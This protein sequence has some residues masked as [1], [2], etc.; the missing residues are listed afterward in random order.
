MDECVSVMCWFVGRL[1]IITRVPLVSGMLM[2]KK[3]KP[4]QQ[5]SQ[6]KLPKKLVSKL[7]K[8][9]DRDLAREFGVSELEI[10][11]E[12]RRLGIAAHGRR[13]WTKKEIAL[14]GTAS[15][16]EI[17]KRLNRIPSGVFLQR[18]LPFLRTQQHN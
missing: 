16:A 18:I 8:H 5:A 14:L 4:S 11:K 7:G 9:N 2:K 10:G 12:R 15:D 3:K 17:A 1:V 6:S 13:E